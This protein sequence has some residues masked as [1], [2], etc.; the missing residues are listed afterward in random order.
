MIAS[1]TTTSSTLWKVGDVPSRL[2]HHFRLC[3]RRRQRPRQLP[4]AGLP[5]RDS[6]AKC[7]SSYLGIST[8]C[9]LITRI[10]RMK[11]SSCARRVATLANSNFDS[12]SISSP[13]RRLV[14][15]DNGKNALR[16]PECLPKQKYPSGNAS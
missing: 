13:T 8:I 15:A 16:R 1:Q 12:K 7:V 3:Q 9:A 5:I 14:S 4:P 10:T 6:N 2:C 11:I